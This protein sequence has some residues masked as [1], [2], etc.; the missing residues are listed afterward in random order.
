MS[1][2]TSTSTSTIELSP[3]VMPKTMTLQATVLD[4]SVFTIVNR[5][6]E[7]IRIDN[8][9]RIF[10]YGR[11]ILTDEEY[12]LTMLDLVKVL[13]DSMSTSKNDNR[14]DIISC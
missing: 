3:R 14:S 2:I 12:R 7:V 1:E 13:I 5:D 9:G 8:E 4:P 11:E 10:W 6:K